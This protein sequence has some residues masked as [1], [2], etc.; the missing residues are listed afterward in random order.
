MVWCAQLIIQIVISMLCEKVIKYMQYNDN[1]FCCHKSSVRVESQPHDLHGKTLG[2]RKRRKV[3]ENPRAERK[4]QKKEEDNK[5]FVG[6]FI[7]TTT[8]ED[9]REYF[10]QFGELI[11]CVVMFGEYGKSKC[12]GF[13]TFRDQ[14]TMEKC[15]NFK[16]HR[17][18]G[19]TVGLT[20]WR[21]TPPKR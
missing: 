1:K 19:R 9:L 7:P 21:R 12:Y 4:E 3:S 13:V 5:L 14:S 6:G 15:F 2:L 8:K 16:P 10:E 11:D 17:L 20:R 18:H